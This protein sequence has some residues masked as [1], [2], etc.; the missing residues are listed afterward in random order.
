MATRKSRYRPSPSVPPQLLPRLAAIVEVLA[1]AKTVSEAA[2]S[3]SLSRNHFQSI[4]HRGLEGLI[5]AITVKA[6]GRPGKPARVAALEKDLKRLERENARLKRQSDSTERLLSV[7]SGLLKGRL[8]P[9]GRQRR[10]KKTSGGS[11]ESGSGSDS[12]PDGR[13]KRILA[14]VA[15]MRRLG[16]SEKVAAAIAGVNPSTLWRWRAQPCRARSRESAFLPV[17]PRVSLA[18]S[19][20]CEALVRRL[21]GLIGAEALR[22]SV[23]GLSRRAA[24]AVKAH[25]L[26]LIERERK[27]ALSRIRISVPGVLR[28]L[29]AM[30]LSTSEGRRY[31]LIGADGA[32]PFRTSLL[33][34]ER[35]D[36]ALVVRALRA[37]FQRHG[38]PL[39]LRL[40][41]ASAHRT[42]SVRELLAD[43]EVVALHGP[44]RYPAFY[45]QLE[46]QNREHRAWI[47]ALGTPLCGAL[48]P[49]LTEMI[50]AVNSLWRRRS[51]QWQTA[52]EVWNARSPL[53]I[54]RRMFREEVHD[55]ALRIAR[56][57]KRRG[58]SADLAERLA[59]ER[60]L[61]HRGYLRRELGGWC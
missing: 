22:H 20:R 12:D 34:D 33:M 5:G 4:L 31:A 19:R 44:P 55:R 46:R 37:D 3:L 32:V 10:T 11:G 61:E 49:C 52:A 40:D 38:P 54:D 14:G 29:D 21:H 47:G 8:R 45:G 57:L 58:Q 2:R 56:T 18:S 28:G 6:R 15:Q 17:K 41:R 30:Q 24:A 60:T 25:T 26:T 23:A 36:T 48:E 27:A 9:T 35:Y 50:E 13:R 7:A 43:Y 59:I 16:L 1:G 42:L 39:V 51:L 53:M